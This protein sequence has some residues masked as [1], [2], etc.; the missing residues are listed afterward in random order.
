MVSG[1]ELAALQQGLQQQHEHFA[2]ACEDLMNLAKEDNAE[3]DR[4]VATGFEGL[5]EACTELDRKLSQHTT[6]QE[7]RGDDLRQVS[8]HSLVFVAAVVLSY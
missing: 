4:Q 7:A 1:A 5:E 3:Q 6:S 2:K 8:P